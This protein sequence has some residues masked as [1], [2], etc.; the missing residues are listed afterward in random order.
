M[1]KELFLLLSNMDWP[2]LQQKQ[3]LYLMRNYIWDKNK[4]K[5][6]SET[7]NFPHASSLFASN[8]D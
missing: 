2:F 5:T 1:L 3:M 6:Y 4:S 8:Q 7:V